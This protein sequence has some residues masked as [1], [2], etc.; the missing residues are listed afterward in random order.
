MQ[1]ENPSQRR[2]ATDKTEGREKMSHSMADIN[3]TKKVDTWRRKFLNL[4]LGGSLA[5]FV[6]AALYPFVRF[7]APQE[8]TEGE[9]SGRVLIG[10][11]QE[12]PL[13][14]FVKFRF[15][16][17]PCLAV[18]YQGRYYAYGAIC[19]HLGCIVNWS[20]DEE[21]ITC[22]CHDGSFDPRTGKVLAGPPP[23]PLPKLRVIEEGGELYA[24]G[25]DD[26]D[27]VKKLTVYS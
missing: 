16:R 3:R 22:P 12:I 19:T 14:A 9:A 8:T 13:G 2:H 10:R 25:W 1:R 20:K 6:A 18:N 4:L 7:L 23:S 27:Y 15:G 24:Q 11:A 26:P 5:A 17:A 21:E